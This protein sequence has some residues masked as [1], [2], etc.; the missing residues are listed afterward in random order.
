[1]ALCC[2]ADGSIKFPL[3]V[4]GESTNP[5]YFKRQT[6]SSKLN[7]SCIYTN[8]KRPWMTKNGFIKWLLAFENFIKNKGENVLLLMDNFSGHFPNENITRLLPLKHVKIVYLPANTTSAI[9]PLDQG[10]IKNFKEFY[11]DLLNDEKIKYSLQKIGTDYNITLY[12]SILLSIKAWDNLVSPETISNS[13]RHSSILVDQDS[14]Y[15]PLSRYVH[16]STPINLDT[17][18]QILSPFY[19]E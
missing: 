8:S 6:G 7:L 5:R 15:V 1:M 16:A 3:T 4:I 17:I 12:D 2:N 11:T 13:F 9:Q 18:N 14:V 19:S 10:I